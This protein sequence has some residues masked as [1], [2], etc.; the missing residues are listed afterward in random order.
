MT[1]RRMPAAELRRLIHEARAW[2]K[3]GAAPVRWAVL[4]LAR[5]RL[6]N[7]HRELRERSLLSARR[8]HHVAVWHDRVL[9]RRCAIKAQAVEALIA[10]AWP[11]GA[12]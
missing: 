3:H 11:R 5:R 1:R 9:A 10:R 6:M 4:T 8:G 2:E 7:R 12:S